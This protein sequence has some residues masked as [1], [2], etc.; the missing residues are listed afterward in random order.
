MCALLFDPLN[1]GVETVGMVCD[2]DRVVV[3]SGGR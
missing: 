3:C 1:D 2:D